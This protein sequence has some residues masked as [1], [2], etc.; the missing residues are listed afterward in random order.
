MAWQLAI[1]F[2]NGSEAAA[3]KVSGSIQFP[4]VNKAANWQS[5]RFTQHM[6]PADKAKLEKYQPFQRDQ[7]AILRG[8]PNAL[9]MLGMLSNTDKHRRLQLTYVAPAVYEFMG[10]FKTV[11]DCVQ[12]T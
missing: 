11:R 12:V 1:R 8:V 7:L 3:E 5:H 6:V 4:I 2:F 9:G 10:W